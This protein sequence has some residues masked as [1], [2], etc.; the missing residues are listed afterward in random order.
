MNV[1]CSNISFMIF[2]IRISFITNASVLANLIFVESNRRVQFHCFVT[3]SSFLT[4]SWK[5]IHC[6]SHDVLPIENY[7]KINW[8][9]D[10]T[11]I[12]VFFPL[13]SAIAP[14]P[15]SPFKEI[16]SDACVLF[17][18]SIFKLTTHAT[19]LS[20]ISLAWKK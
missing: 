11:P 2:I 12:I 1:L 9:C 3:T 10:R 19:V 17:K 14:P 18:I 5:I 6:R 20:V 13:T 15:L 4:A 7:L 8:L 16:L